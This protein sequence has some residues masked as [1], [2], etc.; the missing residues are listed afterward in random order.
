MSVLLVSPLYYDPESLSAK[1]GGDH[2]DLDTYDRMLSI[3]WGGLPT[4]AFVAAL[5]LAA[6]GFIVLF[7]RQRSLAGYLALLAVGPAIFLTISGAVWIHGGQ[8]FGR[9]QLPLQPLLLFLGSFGALDLARTLG[10]ARGE[11]AAWTT[12]VALSAAYLVATPA[13][14]QVARLGTWFAHIDYHWDYRYRWIDYK[15]ANSSLDPPDFYRKLGSMA[16]GTIIEAPYIWEAPHNPLAYYATYHHQN[17]LFGMIHDLC[18]QA[19]RIGEV[20][21]NDRRFRFRRFVFLANREQ[22]RTSGARYL[23]FNRD[24]PV[25][26]SPLREQCIARLTE[27]YGTPAQADART[28]VWDLSE[29]SQKPGH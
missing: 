4:P 14:A 17:E 9:Y 15:R 7:R 11:A 12:C 24:L 23:I 2:P 19:G 1:A 26:F 10:R 8:N 6:W 21:P 28:V 3:F 16:P 25:R 27:L 5:A 13:I 18:R 22:V 29:M 20:P